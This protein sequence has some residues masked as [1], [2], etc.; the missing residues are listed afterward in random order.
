MA[1]DIAA[2]MMADLG[3]G[4]R[5]LV[6][7]PADDEKKFKKA[8]EIAARA[9]EQA[10]VNRT[11]T[12]HRA[13]VAKAAAAIKG[14]D[15]R[16]AR[17]KKWSGM[18]TYTFFLPSHSTNAMTDQAV[19][20]KDEITDQLENRFDGQGHRA[21]LKRRFGGYDEHQEAVENTRGEE[22]TMWLK[23]QGRQLT[24][25][26]G[27]PTKQDNYLKHVLGGESSR[28]PKASRTMT[29]QNTPSH[30]RGRLVA[31]A[32]RKR[33]QSPQGRTKFVHDQKVNHSGSS[34]QAATSAAGST[35]AQSDV[36]Q[37]AAT[38]ALRST[39]A[40][41]GV[42]QQDV[43]PFN[44]HSPQE[45]RQSRAVPVRT[46]SPSR[47][48]ASSASR[49][50]GRSRGPVSTRPMTKN[51]RPALL[52]P[53]E[54]GRY[55]AQA[56]W[57]AAKPGDK[58]D[59][60]HQKYPERRG[61]LEWAVGELAKEIT[62]LLKKGDER[63][64]RH[65]LETHPE[66]DWMVDIVKNAKLLVESSTNEEIEAD[67][68]A[69]PTMAAFIRSASMHFTPKPRRDSGVTAPGA[70]ANGVTGDTAMP[71]LPQETTI[72]TNGIAATEDLQPAPENEA[73]EAMDVTAAPVS[74]FNSNAAMNE[75]SDM[76][77]SSPPQLQKGR[78]NGVH[79]SDSEE[80]AK[81]SSTT[82][83][84]V[85]ASVEAPQMQGRLTA[86]FYDTNGMFVGIHQREVQAPVMATMNIA[87]RD[88]L[89]NPQ[90]L[91]AAID[92]LAQS[93]A[94]NSNANGNPIGAGATTL[95]G[96]EDSDDEEL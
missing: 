87:S 45:A 57:Y 49:R 7:A 14:E 16:T 43:T 70:D 76:N 34:Q 67:Y 26:H 85:E 8:Q 38:P 35:T 6:T 80:E 47:S 55:K 52:N 2:K 66:R 91:I 5:D 1:G 41:S 84:E 20:D 21:G 61:Y 60:Y 25:D 19:F 64:I 75:S 13:R 11:V 95:V 77:S 17:I 4:R 68:K 89:Y 88:A 28:Q 92:G 39:A 71:D 94:A 23:Q 36:A 9:R 31:D 40:Q 18:Y 93:M 50:T 53:A 3:V 58:S 63:D 24:K 33:A 74:T 27:G 73:T 83:V 59:E 42:P 56:L 30:G 78:T 48:H 46:P 15:D 54:V 79:S 82:S 32:N 22:R 62:L 86:T 65:Y 29:S 12:A 96:Y 51:T 44:T 10:E 90:Q 69:H 37:Q 81:D 72:T